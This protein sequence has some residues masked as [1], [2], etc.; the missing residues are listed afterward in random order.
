VEAYLIS[1]GVWSKQVKSFV[2]VL[3]RAFFLMRDI[4]PSKH[5]QNT[6]NSDIPSLRQAAKGKG[7]SNAR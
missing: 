7:I 3:H 6:P 5:Q 2:A 1:D 4:D